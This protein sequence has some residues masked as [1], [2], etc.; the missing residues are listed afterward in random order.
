MGNRSLS[1]TPESLSNLLVQIFVAITT[2]S[3][4][5]SVP[6]EKMNVEMLKRIGVEIGEI[7]SDRLKSF[8]DPINMENFD[9]ITFEPESGYADPVATSNS[10]ASRAGELGATININKKAKKIKKDENGTPL[11]LF[12]HQVETS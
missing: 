10:F 12:F 4:T 3:Y 5:L 9:Y 2:R 8:Y 1:S 7:G 6:S 11:P